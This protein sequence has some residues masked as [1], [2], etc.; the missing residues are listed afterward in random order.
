VFERAGL[1]RELAVPPVIREIMS[2]LKDGMK[3]RPEYWETLREAVF[4]VAQMGNGLRPGFGAD[5]APAT[6]FVRASH[7]LTRLCEL[8]LLW[9]RGDVN[10][11]ELA[12]LAK[13]IN[14]T[15]QV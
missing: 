5:D 1:V 10:L 8:L 12:Y 9:E 4:E 13:S 3:P 14:S 7:D 2:A 6:A 15:P 11:T